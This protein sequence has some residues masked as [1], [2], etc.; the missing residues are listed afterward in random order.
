M[1]KA[2]KDARETWGV[3]S[4]SLPW[5]STCCYGGDRC[6]KVFVDFM[7]SLQKTRWSSTLVTSRIRSTF[8][9]C[10]ISSRSWR[11]TLSCTAVDDKWDFEALPQVCRREII[12]IT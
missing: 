8:I 10:K 2:I 4:D 5:S 3:L 1:V 12:E 7:S 11:D 9:A 6:L